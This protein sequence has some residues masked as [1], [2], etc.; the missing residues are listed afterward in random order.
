MIL[1]PNPPVFPDRWASSW[2]EDSYGLWQAFDIDGVRQVMRW[3]VPGQFDMGSPTSEQ[4]RGDKETQHRVRISHGFWLADTAC[5]QALWQQVMGKNPSQFNDNWQNPVEQVSWDDCQEFITTLNQTLGGHLTLR[6]P[7]EAQ[8]EYACRAGTT[9]VF[10]TGANITTAQANYNGNFPYADAPKGE[11]REQTVAVDS[12]APNSWGLYQMHGNVWEWCEDEYSKYLE[13]FLTDPVGS[14]PK[15]EEG[16]SR[17]LRGGSWDNFAHR[18]RS[19][20][21][22]RSPPDDRIRNIGLRLAGG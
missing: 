6:L 5:T 2:G 8:W 19:A 16:H 17:V 4:N 7:T 22:D 20:S 15:P 10:N 9:S 3:I 1:D 21:R 12:F 11:Y 14:R 13:G 18:L